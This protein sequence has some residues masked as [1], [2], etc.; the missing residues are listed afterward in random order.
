MAYNGYAI[1]ADN[2]LDAAAVT[3]QLDA[4]KQKPVYTIGAQALKEY[5]E[6]YFEKKC[7]KS[8]EMISQAKRII[9]GGV[10]HNL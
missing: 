4:L 10:Q 3:A 5:E 7:P 9:P 8:K 1:D 6:E 2:Y